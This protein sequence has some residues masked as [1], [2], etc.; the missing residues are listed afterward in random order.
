MEKIRTGEGLCALGRGR[1]HTLSFIFF[2]IIF[3]DFYFNIILLI[4]FL[5]FLFLLIR[6][7]HLMMG[8]LLQRFL[9]PSW[10]EEEGKKILENLQVH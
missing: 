6:I 9:H 3:Y 5:F 2:K 10:T 1:R 7:F 8:N 4:N